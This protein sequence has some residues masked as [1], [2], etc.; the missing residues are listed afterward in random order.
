MKLFNLFKGTEKNQQQG[1]SCSNTG[2][3]A[4]SETT[5][6]EQVENKKSLASD[7][8]T[9]HNLIILDESGSMQYIY[10]PAISGVNE[11]LQTIRGA[12]KEHTGQKHFVSL[13]SFHTGH[14]NEIY[15][16]VPAESAID[17][18]Q[19]HYRPEGCTPLYDAMGRAITELRNKVSKEDTVLVTVITD[20]LEN[21]SREYSGPAI[22]ALVEEMKARGW[23]F[24]YIGANQNVEAVAN[25]LSI[26]NS[27]AFDANEASTRN[28]FAREMRSRKKF[29]S[30]LEGNA[31]R[32]ELSKDYFSD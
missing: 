22:K 8:K 1:A 31:S 9:V 25:S 4:G 6:A 16:H 21:A 17:V 5:F 11:T 32:E 10:Q 12:E 2:I 14:Y 15:S 7:S 3:D 19:D 30:K 24:T 13:I 29:F 27:L 18:T 28:M 20:G 26:S 23:V